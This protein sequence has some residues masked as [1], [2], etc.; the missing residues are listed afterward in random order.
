MLRVK[1]P[2]G[3]LTSDQLF[4]LAEIG[5]KYSRHFGHITTRQNIQFHFVKLHDVEPAMRLLAD[6]GI[7]T[8]EAC[9][10]SVRNITGCPYAG[11]SKT[12]VFDISPYAEAMTRFCLRHRLSSSLPRKFKIAFEGCTEDHIAVAINDL[13]F[14]ARIGPDGRR[15][16]R[17]TAGGGTA[18]MCKEA[19]LM[20][21]FL[22]AEEIFRCAEA[23]MRVFKE[24]GD[25][26]HKQRNRIKFMIKSLGWE[27][28]QAE[29]QKA[30]AAC[31]AESVA[32]CQID[33]PASE[34]AP[35]WPKSP[36]PSPNARLGRAADRPGRDARDRA[37]A[38]ARRRGVRPVARDERAR[39]EAIRLRHG[40]G[41]HS[42]R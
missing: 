37:A 30:L 32:L 26:Q 10:N 17:V 40:H 18:L 42:A 14:R 12:E 29:Y 25:Y 5:E 27:R 3:V 21:E 36:A 7:T 13:G 19:G 22:P 9:G 39:P 41:H 4:A 15:G 11:V 24:F 34:A 23:V 20:H 6:A 28:F 16:F 2:Q 35:D 38:A 8:R 31:R 1:V 33:P